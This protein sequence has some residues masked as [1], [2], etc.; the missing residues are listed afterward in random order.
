MERKLSVAD[1]NNEKIKLVATKL[2]EAGLGELVDYYYVE[3]DYGCPFF[4]LTKKYEKEQEWEPEY[5]NVF[6]DVGDEYTV[7]G[8]CLHEHFPLEKLDA[9]VQFA[10]D[11]YNGK[12][13]EV[14]IVSTTMR[15][16][17]FMP[18]T[19]DP[20]KNV[21]FLSSNLEGIANIINNIKQGLAPDI[22]A[23][24]YFAPIH[25]FYLRISVE[26]SPAIAGKSTYLTSVVFGKQTEYYL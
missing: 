1:C 14:C 3:G 2:T 19:G 24:H 7:M 4:K 17:F 18:D 9:A 13:A 20:E 5:V 12:L 16:G 15:V 8:M 26:N 23:H 11:V 6:F 10:V 21:N 22:H 25:P